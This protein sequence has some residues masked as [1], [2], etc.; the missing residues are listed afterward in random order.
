MIRDSTRI[1]MQLAS[2]GRSQ[3]WAGDKIRRHQDMK[4]VDTLRYAVERVP[5][6]RDLGLDADQ[7][8]SGAR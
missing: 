4:L 7:I 1:A 5:H 3:W 2:A 8:T 6:Y